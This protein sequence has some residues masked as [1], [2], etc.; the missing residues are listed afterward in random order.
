MPESLADLPAQ[1]ALALSLASSS[2]GTDYHYLL[3]TARTE[4]S[5]QPQARAQTSSA[6]GLFQFIEET[7][8]RTI[9]DEGER[10]GLGDYSAMIVKTPQGRY[11][12][13]DPKNR[14]AILELR[15]DPRI[16]A[17]MAGVYAQRNA[18]FV[19]A[20]IGRKPTASELYIAHFLG[21]ADAVRLIQLRD[22]QQW[23]SAP[24]LFPQAARSNR[25]I[26]YGDAG[27][28]SVGQVYDL[29]VARSTSSGAGSDTA[30]A[31][32]AGSS[33]FGNWSPTV[34]KVY[35]VSPAQAKTEAAMDGGFSLL[36]L[37]GGGGRKVQTAAADSTA[38]NAAN[39]WDAAVANADDA[40]TAPS[41][42]LAAPAEDVTLTAGSDGTP[43]LLPDTDTE[44]VPPSAPV[45]KPPVAARAA[46]ASDKPRIKIIHVPGG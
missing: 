40:D 5:F 35:D 25:P 4:S 1:V 29:L 16:S 43:H 3:N 15:R 34:E 24:D 11:Y 39:G 23:L 8:I 41:A 2:T 46:S 12:V 38:T 18:E 22:T 30:N 27:P 17:M 14:V 21:P 20:E 37:L 19:A 13:P 10:F 26:F 28:R 36:D 42:V 32:I 31:T 7:W 9:K 45:L 44:T 33:A 6:Q